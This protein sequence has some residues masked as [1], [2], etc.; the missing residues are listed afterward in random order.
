MLTMDTLQ[1]KCGE[2]KVRPAG[3]TA[4]VHINNS[5]ILAAGLYQYLASTFEYFNHIYQ[6][7]LEK[8]RTLLTL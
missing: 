7:K 5:Y 2:A 8:C 4:G 1:T 3:Y 6:K